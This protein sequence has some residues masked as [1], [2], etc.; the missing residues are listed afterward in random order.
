VLDLKNVNVRTNG[1]SAV[2]DQFTKIQDQL[3]TVKADA[4]NQ[5][6]T[7]ITDLSNALSGLGSSLTAAR[8]SLN[9]G[10]LTAVVSSAG[11]VVTAGNSLVSAV[12]TTC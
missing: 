1:V 4:G 2:S 10:T 5:Y 12:S 3:K 9:G 6:S 8:D 7:Q 11:T